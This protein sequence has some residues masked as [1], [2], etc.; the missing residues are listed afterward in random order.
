MKSKDS[1]HRFRGLIAA[2]L[3]PFTAD[4]QVDLGPIP[5][6]ADHLVERGIVGVYVNG[7]TG[8]GP[9]LTTAERRD[10]AE[11]WIAAIDGRIPVMV[12]IGHTSVDEARASAEH[13]R[14]AGADMISACAPFYFP[15]ASEERLFA[16]IEAMTRSVPEL[17]FYY[18]HIPR[19]TGARLDMATLLERVAASDHPSFAGI[20]FSDFALH[21]F[22]E[23][24]HACDGRFELLWG[25]DE[26]SLAALATGAQAFVGST[27]NFAAPLYQQIAQAFESGDMERARELQ[28]RSVDL[29]RVLNRHGG[30]HASLK[31]LLRCERGLELGPARVPLA[32]LSS[33]A[34]AALQ[35]E[36]AALKIE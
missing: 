29:V 15:V 25:V 2:T 30:F 22:I 26:M 34:A 35:A 3:T 24:Q 28:L 1:T 31:H 9:S 4:G 27:Y 6:Y 18:Y 8:E 11:A 21:D 12:Q 16:A 7:S 13:A 32:G 19:L 5:A 17:P 23:C 36:A 10:L 33:D 14:D 20:K